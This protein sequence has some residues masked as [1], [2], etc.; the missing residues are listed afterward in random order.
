MRF[1][2]DILEDTKRKTPPMRA[3]NPGVEGNEKIMQRLAVALVLLVFIGLLIP[4]VLYLTE[5]GYGKISFD[6]GIAQARLESGEDT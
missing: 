5:D 4:V 2:G 6:G 3:P 1:Q